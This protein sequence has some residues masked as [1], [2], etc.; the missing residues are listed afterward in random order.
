MGAHL[1]GIV[2]AEGAGV[3]GVVCSD[4]RAVVRTGPD[5]TFSIE[6][7]GPFVFVSTPT[8]YA[9]DPWYLPAE[10]DLRFDLRTQRQT[11]PFSFAQITDLH[12]STT[13]W[14]FGAPVITTP[15]VVSAF[16]EYV[17]RRDPGLAFVASTGDQTNNGTDEEFA[18]YMSAAGSSPLRVIAIPGNHD[19]NSVDPERARSEGER[20]G[21]GV[22]YTP[23]DRFMGP[24][25]FSF[26][27]AGVHFVVVDWTTHHLGFETEVQEAW[28]RA[29][30]TQ[31]APGTPVIFLTHDLM[32]SA[33]FDST[34]AAPVASFSGHWH[35]SRTVEA[36]GALHVN[37]AP[38]LY[39]GLDYSP[40]SYRI[41][42]W[43]GDRVSVSTVVRGA[44][45][46]TGDAS[47]VWTAALENGAHR[48]GPVLCG[49]LVVAASSDE[50]RPAG[51]VEAFDAATGE[52][53]W[54][55][56]VSSG[57]KTSAVMCGDRIV[58][59]AVT[60]ETVCVDART[61]AEHWR[62]EIDDPLRLWTY[63]RPVTDGKR[64]YVGDTA[65][66]LA[67]DCED[68][69]VVWSRDDLGV[70]GNITCHSHPVVVDGV[71]IVAFSAQV[72]DM[73][74]LDAATGA[75]IWP[76]GAA[77]ASVYDLEDDDTAAH[78]VRCPV[79]G[80]TRDPDD[81][82]VYVARLGNLVDRIRVADGSVVW[83]SRVEGW[84]NPAPPVVDGDDVFVCEGTGTVRCLARADGTLRWKTTVTDTCSLHMGPYRDDGGAL[85]GEPVLHDGY[86]TVACGD[87]R[88]V[89]LSRADGSIDSSV[90]FGVP[91]AAPPAI[92]GALLYVLGVD[93]TLRALSITS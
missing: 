58:A 27:H 69:S 91:F 2:A 93:G 40:A 3:G 30:L 70:R 31:V 82:D 16:F 92:R 49:D 5:G 17:A 9:A 20:F 51:S 90:D 43:D 45:R 14:A 76:A 68:G 23:Y 35:T 6:A 39:G 37:T 84:F 11:V 7:S 74:A 22:Y 25:W 89:T 1:R 62:T 71:L 8:G 73:W 53:R 78:L 55:V 63:L 64:V 50:D 12:L 48:G 13:G 47:A 88:L 38:A 56:E 32:S 18:G 19:H 83:S 33:F 42:T 4:G 21:P 85:F 44:E 66:F 15:E 87:G 65:R 67:L 46:A 59:S 75:T 57:I 81:A 79:S 29:D 61:G 36:A 52:R 72:P 77:P 60:G 41:V 54:S 86:L 28:V 24:R 34:G 80:F 10:G 26:D